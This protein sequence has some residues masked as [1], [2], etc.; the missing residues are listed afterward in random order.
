M[1]NICAYNM[2][3]KVTIARKNHK[4]NSIQANINFMHQFLLVHK[5]EVV[6]EHEYGTEN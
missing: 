3:Q 5:N 6:D 4:T 1:I 2:A